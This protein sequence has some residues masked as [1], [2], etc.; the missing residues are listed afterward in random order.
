MS[1]AVVPP[2]TATEGVLGRRLL[3]WL[4]DVLLVALL[5]AVLHLLLG[6]VGLLTL[7]LGWGLFALTP[8]VP[9]AYSFLFLASR[10]AATPGQQ[11]LGLAVLHDQTQRRPTALEALVSTALFW[12]SL[13]VPLLL[14]VPLLN[15]RHR[16]LHDLASGL[17]MVRTGAAAP[18]G[19]V[20][21]MSGPRA[22]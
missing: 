20:W 2:L 6:I 3:A 12:I 21:N 14:L 7:G 17:A 18:A 22:A 19:G 15:R 11:L 4:A 16:T 5:M 9:F 8:L 1:G 13:G 10:H